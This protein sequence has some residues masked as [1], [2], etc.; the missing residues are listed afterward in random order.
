M[1]NKD[2]IIKT[3]KVSKSFSVGGKQ[4]HVIKNLDME[5]RKGDFTVVMGAS[6]S[7]KSTLLY[8]LSGMDK[9]SLGKINYCGEDITDMNDDKLAVFRRKHC[10][11]V[12]Q[13]IHLVD[14]MSIMDNAISTGMLTGQKQKALKEKASKLFDRVG[15]SA[16]LTKKFPSQL[17]GGEAQRSAM[18]RALI[19]DPDV[20]FA[21]EPTGAL[22]SA[23]VKAVLDVLTEINE[24]GQSVVMVTHDMK[25]ARRGN[26]I[27]YLKDGGIMGECELGKYVSGDKKRHEKLKRFLEDMGW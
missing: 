2:V 27:I 17:S 1:A 7:G 19:N 3:E 24:G 14:S 22:N 9:P 10:G 11:F 25:S 5:I 18:V 15:I 23:G 4:Q 21:D 8:T 16:D 12:F 20:V 26:R 13:Q 6:G